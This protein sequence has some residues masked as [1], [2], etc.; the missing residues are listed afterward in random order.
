MVKLISHTDLTIGKCWNRPL[1]SSSINLAKFMLLGA[2]RTSLVWTIKA[3]LLQNFL[4]LRTDKAALW[5]IRDIAK[6]VYQQ[7]PEDHKFLFKDFI[8]GVR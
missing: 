6:A 8:K 3:R 1:K 7:L 4:K 5:E 2:Y